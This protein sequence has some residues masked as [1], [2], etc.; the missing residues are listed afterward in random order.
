MIYIGNSFEMMKA[1]KE[2]MMQKI[3]MTNLGLMHYFLCM[4]VMQ[5]ASGISLYQKKYATNILKK[6]G[7]L[8]CKASKTP[9]KANENYP[10]K[11]ELKR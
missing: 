5:D 7:M 11:M 2:S 10:W 8:N 9:L 1:F 3:E 6:F 4:K